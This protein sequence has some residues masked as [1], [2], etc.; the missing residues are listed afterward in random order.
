[1]WAVVL[2]GQVA[3]WLRERRLPR[4]DCVVPACFV[5]VAGYAGYCHAHFSLNPLRVLRRAKQPVPPPA[6]A[7][8]ALAGRSPN[9]G[10]EY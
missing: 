7:T 4:P 10:K 6:P 1:M 9:D 8:H 5:A 2:D 3:V